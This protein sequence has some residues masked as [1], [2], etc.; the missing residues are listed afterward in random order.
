MHCIV[1]FK[2]ANRLFM[3]AI[4]LFTGATLKYLSSYSRNVSRSLGAWLPVYR[5]NQSG[6]LAPIF[7]VAISF[8]V[9]ISA[10]AIEFGRWAV[11]QNELQANID[12]AVLAGAEKLQS[13]RADPAA[14]IAAA[15]AVF[16]A[17]SAKARFKSDITSGVTFSVD[18]NSV[19]SQ[20][21][22]ELASVLGSVVGVSGFTLVSDTAGS[23]L[24]R[25]TSNAR[26]TISSDKFEISLMLDITGSMC[27]SAPAQA[28]APC[29]TGT[30]ISALKTAATNLVNTL[31]ST[32]ELQARV[33]V[34]L[35]PFSDGV[36]PPAAVLTSVRGVKPVIPTPYVYRSNNKNVTAYYWATDC[37]A[38][39]TGS[40]AFTDA[41]PGLLTN[42]FMT[43]MREGTSL[44][45]STPI[46]Y[47]GCTLGSTSEVVPLTNVA[48]T[49]TTK[50]AALGAKGGTAG[51]VGTAWAWY[52]LS[53]RWNDI[54]P[55]TAN[56][57]GPYAIETPTDVRKI[58]VLMTD[59]DYTYQFANG[60]YSNDTRPYSSLGGAANGSSSTQAGKLCDGM[61]AKGIEVYTIGFAVS[62]AAKTFLEKCATDAGHAFTADTSAGLISAFEGIAQRVVALYLSK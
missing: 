29:Q 40:E 33:R 20:G 46:A 54:W 56:D 26:A 36:R 39:R 61:K 10:L 53:P 9:F 52:T 7:A 31:L 47:D 35:A 30:K 49:L 27:D 38:E 21:S 17:N 55:G 23:G 60:G 2:L 12:A 19:V 44:T 15:K 25:S 1:H 34:A 50:I 6:A 42:Q 28:A 57:A 22:A 24:G 18:G 51:H 37:V 3:R 32:T 41:A 43:V 13:N 45:N 58:A 48:A 14:A 4:R 59:G 62:S 5:S 16:D 11:A 8:L